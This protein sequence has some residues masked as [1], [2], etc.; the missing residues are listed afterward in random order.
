V[1]RPK[2]MLP[3][4]GQE[5]EVGGPESARDGAQGCTDD[6]CSSPEMEETTAA[7]SKIRA[8]NPEAAEGSAAPGIRERTVV[9]VED[10]T[11][12]VAR[13]PW[14]SASRRCPAWRGRP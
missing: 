8:G 9:R 2:K 10:W 6:C 11:V 12:R 14:R 4:L 3:V 5:L 1:S 13:P 7:T